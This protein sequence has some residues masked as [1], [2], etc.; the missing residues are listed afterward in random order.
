M[1][2][3][4][5]EEAPARPLVDPPTEFGSAFEDLRGWVLGVRALDVQDCEPA[6]DLCILDGS[7]WALDHEAGPAIAA[8]GEPGI[9]LWKLWR[10]AWLERAEEGPELVV[11]VGTPQTGKRLP[12]WIEHIPGANLLDKELLVAEVLPEESGPG[13]S[14]DKGAADAHRGHSHGPSEALAPLGVHLH[15]LCNPGD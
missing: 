15:V 3:E 10:P 14:A 9:W 5:A 12:A 4:W 13:A 7:Q 11:G 6:A 1:T 2:T 8:Q